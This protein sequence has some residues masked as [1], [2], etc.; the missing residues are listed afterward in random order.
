MENERYP[1][2]PLSERPVIRWPGEARVAF[3][4]IP[5]VEHFRFDRPT[6]DPVY[7]M[8]VPDVPSFAQRDYGNRVGIW[9]LMEVLDR[10]RLRATVALNAD[11]CHFYP[12]IIK[13]GV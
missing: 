2:W 5:N 3:W 13:A 6:S 8:P 11:V 12:Q 1:Y 4:V 7:D 10:H 9:R